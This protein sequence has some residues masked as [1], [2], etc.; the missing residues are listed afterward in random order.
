MII[1]QSI[2]HGKRV[3]RQQY[4]LQRISFDEAVS[5]LEGF[6]D[7]PTADAIRNMLRKL[8]FF[9]SDSKDTQRLIWMCQFLLENRNTAQ[10][11]QTSDHQIWLHQIN[12]LLL[13]CG[14]HHGLLQEFQ[15]K[16]HNKSLPLPI[17]PLT[18]VYLA[19]YQTLVFEMA[20]HPIFQAEVLFISLAAAFGKSYWNPWLLLIIKN[21]LNLPLFEYSNSNH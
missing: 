2:I 4:E 21:N 14:S 10:K 17:E 7:T 12:C 3:R 19:S 1:I 15:Q 13:I 9:Y 16:P 5:S 8:L 6:K 11:L 20:L 18:K